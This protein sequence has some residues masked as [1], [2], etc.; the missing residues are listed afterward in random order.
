MPDGETT[1]LP[2]A[3]KLPLQ[4]ACTGLADAEQ[5]ASAAIIFSTAQESV[6]CPP[7]NTTAG[8]AVKS[9][10]SG[11][12]TTTVTVAES[13]LEPEALLQVNV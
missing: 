12:G 7:L 13:D 10:I 5:P 9:V 2:E 4:S 3:G 1:L 8:A 11:G 6:V